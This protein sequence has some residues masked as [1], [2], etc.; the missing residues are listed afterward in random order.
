MAL[1]WPKNGNAKVDSK[2]LSHNSGLL[3]I[4]IFKTKQTL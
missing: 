4:V 1:L 2:K 3:L